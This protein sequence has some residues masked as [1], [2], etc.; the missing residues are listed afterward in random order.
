VRWPQATLRAARADAIEQA[1]AG[2]VLDR[3]VAPAARILVAG[4]ADDSIARVLAERGARVDTWHR[5][6]APGRR[7][8]AWPPEVEVDAAVLRQPRARAALEL[9]LHAVAGRLPAGG[10]LWLVGSNQ[11]G[12]RSVPGR[13]EPLFEDV[14]TV[15][16]RRHGR[17]LRGRRRAD[18]PGLRPSLADWRT[19]GTVQLGPGAAARP[20]TTYPG[21]FA[22]G[23]L[24]PATALLVEALPALPAGCRVLDFGCGSGII[25]AALAARGERIELDQLDADALAVAAARENLPAARTYLGSGLADVPDPARWD[26]VASNPPIHEATVRSYRTLEA[27]AAAVGGRLAPGGEVWLVAQRQ[28]P[29]GDLLTRGGLRPELAAQR[30]GFRVWR[31]GR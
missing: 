4:E 7:A 5:F 18:I 8:A 13:L 17:L 14:V 10:E 9:A 2:L 26:L 21:L 6:A 1:M 12:V 25:G 3:L 31:A 19:V 20:W 15:D 16:A 30:G 23:G 27:L 22:H 29:A 11:E 28:V 24:D